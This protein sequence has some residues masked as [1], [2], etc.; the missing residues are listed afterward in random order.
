M[1]EELL[2]EQVDGPEEK[3][4]DSV[5]ISVATGDTL[6]VLQLQVISSP[7]AK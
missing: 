3:G 7:T 1:E 2:E 4:G 5:S 6:A